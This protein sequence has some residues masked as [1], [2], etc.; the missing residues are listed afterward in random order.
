M[1]IA[2]NKPAETMPLYCDSIGYDWNQ[3]PIHRLNGYY[4]Y[5][6][7]QTETGTVVINI[8]HQSIP[9]KATQGILLRPRIAHEY[10]PTGNQP[11]KVSFL[12]FNGTLVDSLAD[13]LKLTDFLVIDKVSPEL[14]AFIPEVLNEF[15]NDHPIALLDQSVQIYKFFMLLKQNH[16]LNNHRYQDA[17][18]TTPIL[19]YIANHYAEPITNDKLAKAT[20]YSVTYQ[21]RVFKRLYDMTPLEYLTD[22]RMR[23]AKELLLTNPTLE[24]GEIAPKVGF[25]NPSHFIDQFKKY[26]KATPSHFRKFI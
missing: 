13:F 10:H 16:L 17:T 2:F 4:A 3:P 15:N 18:I 14:T 9:L 7:L 5:H 8:D 21:N 26:Y 11:W 23:K 22:Y 24:I 20:S 19:Q 12:T 1:R 6:W 25:H